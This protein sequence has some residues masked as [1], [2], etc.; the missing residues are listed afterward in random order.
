VLVQKAGPDHDKTFWMEVKIRDKTYGPGEGKNKK[1]AEQAAAGIA[2]QE[3]A[4]D[5]E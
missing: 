3:L 1:E 4:R 5:G 2:Y